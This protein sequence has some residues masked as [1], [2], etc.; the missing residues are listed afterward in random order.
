MV[1]FLGLGGWVNSTLI[2]EG[3]RDEAYVNETLSKLEEMAVPNIPIIAAETFISGPY[4]SEI[5]NHPSLLNHTWFATSH[6]NWNYT[7]TLSAIPE[8]AEMKIINPNLDRE[9]DQSNPKYQALNSLYYAEFGENMT[10]YTGNVYDAVWLS[11]LTVMETGEYNNV[12]FIETFPEIAQDYTGVSGN[13]SLDQYG[14][15][16]HAGYNIY[17]Y[18][19]RGENVYLKE[20]GYCD[21]SLPGIQWTELQ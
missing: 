20:I 3:I 18:V 17:K 1:F 4:F 16:L 13:C 2:H 7:D 14:D 10:R 21:T 8:L 19:L 15:R 11:A 6:S 9:P 12:T 5:H